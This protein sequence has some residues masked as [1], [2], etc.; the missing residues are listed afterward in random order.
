[1]RF[2]EFIGIDVSKSD[3][4]V[5]IHSTKLHSKFKNNERGFEK[6][7]VWIKA[8]GACELS[9]TVFAF[10]H[11]GLYS[12]QLSRFLDSAKYPFTLLSGLA[13]KKSLG[14]TRGKSDKADARRIAEYTYEKKDKI[15]LYKMPSGTLLKLKRLA[16]YRERL[17]AGRA[18]FK[19]RVGEQESILDPQENDVLF[20]SQKETIAFYNKQINTVEAELCKLI[21]SDEKLNE[22]YEL[23]NS[24]KGVGP[25][26]AIMM[27]ILTDGFSSFD[28]WRQ[29]AC[30][31]GIA[32]FP[33]GSGTFI[34][35]SKTSHL[36]NRRIKALLSSCA[37]SAIQHSPEMKIYYN[38][39][40]EEGKHKMSTL[41]IVKNKLLSRIF[42]V[43]ARGT[44]YVDT[45]Q[46]AS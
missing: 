1:M 43:V 14:L 16:S 34:G 11:T 40:L 2:K 32:P 3:I 25:Q 29:F 28:K 6:M 38:R 45:Y 27:I 30:Y 13:V 4:D 8:N 10:E 46:F 5:F 18:A 36:A 42:V 37:A 41:N 44:P 26:T 22:Q 7:I 35:R 9:E 15:R 21:K 23:I 12:L 19:A 31:A 17:V 24:I 20:T 39:R 33:N